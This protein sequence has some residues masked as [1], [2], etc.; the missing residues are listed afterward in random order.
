M[1]TTYSIVF[2]QSD[3]SNSINSLDLKLIKYEIDSVLV[4][5]N[6]IFSTYI[7]KSEI[8]SINN[9]LKDANNEILLSSHFDKVFK[10]AIY[11]CDLSNGLYDITILPLID[12]W[13]FNNY[14]N[15]LPSKSNID[16]TLKFVG[17]KKIISNDIPS[18]YSNERNIKI[19]LNSLAKGYGVDVLYE[20]LVKK[21]D[22]DFLIEIG[23]EIRTKTNIADI[24][25]DW[26]IGIQNPLK[27]SLIKSINLNNLALATSGTYNNYFEED[28]LEYSHIINPTTGYPIEHHILSVSVIA[29][30]CIDADA[31]AT[32]LMVVD[33]KDGIDI[34]NNIDKTEC[35]IITKNKNSISLN[36]SDGFE[37]FI[38]E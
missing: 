19:D 7:K 32:M 17:Y 13:G 8:N 12:L 36:Y 29:P 23:G 15:I 3:N 24:G 4:D 35:L 6:D 21:V 28:G 5:L 38:V 10:K 9:A 14:N 30:D 33:W 34:I 18:I 26:I 27:K 2:N 20:Y 22:V 37:D 16:S 31:L 1:G 25:D 11:Y